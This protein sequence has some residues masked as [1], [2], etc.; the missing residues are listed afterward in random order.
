MPDNVYAYAPSCVANTAVT[1][2]V[3][4]ALAGMD[5]IIPRK[6]TITI[7]DGHAGLTGIAVAFGHNAVIPANAGAYISGNDWTFPFDLTGYPNGVSW[8]V[9]MVNGDIIAHVWQV[10]FEGDNLPDTPGSV[11]AAPPTAEQVMAAA[12]ADLGGP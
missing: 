1:A 10:I 12:V 2:P 3:E 4:F 7:P 11:A 5:P 9:L 6:V 8:S